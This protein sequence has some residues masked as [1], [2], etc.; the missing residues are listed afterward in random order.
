MLNIDP[1]DLEQEL[2][3]LVER[4]LL[5]PL[6]ILLGS[7]DLAAPLREHLKAQTADWAR[8]LLGADDAAAT[9]TASRLLA[10]LFGG[11]EFSPPDSWWLTSFGRIV[12]LRIGYPGRPTI[13]PVEAAAMLGITRQ[14]VHDLIRRGKLVKAADGKL[15]TASVQNRLKAGD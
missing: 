6:E 15:V 5:D 12:A 10:V 4:R 11:D 2:L 9:G 7:P 3:A 14:G 1:D 8:D 13:A